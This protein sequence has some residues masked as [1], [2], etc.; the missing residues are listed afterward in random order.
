MSLFM[1]HSCVSVYFLNHLFVYLMI[2]NIM[3]IIYIYIYDHICIVR[4]AKLLQLDL[5][6]IVDTIP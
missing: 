6:V 2:Y 3:Y 4:D 1:L 5:G